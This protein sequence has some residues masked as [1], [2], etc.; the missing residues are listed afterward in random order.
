MLLASPPSEETLGNNDDVLGADL[1]VEVG[2]NGPL[3]EAILTGILIPFFAAL[4]VKPPARMIALSTVSVEP[5]RVCRRRTHDL[6]K[7]KNWSARGT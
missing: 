5:S 6:A 4:S 7:M 2:F 3:L 1:A